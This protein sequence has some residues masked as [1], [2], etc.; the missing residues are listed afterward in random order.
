MPNEVDIGSNIA[1]P[2]EATGSQ[3]EIQSAEQ[4]EMSDLFNE[5][6]AS[7]AK[8][9]TMARIFQ[10]VYGDDVAPEEV[11]AFSLV[12][13]SELHRLARELQLEPGQTIV[14]LACGGGGP[15]LWVAREIQANLVGIDISSV[16]IAQAARRAVEFGLNHR[17]SFKVADFAA[18]GLPD[19]AFAGAISIDALWLAL[20]KLEALREVA[21]I[22]RPGA[23]FVFTT[24][25]ATIP[26]P[27]LPPQIDDHRPLLRQAGFEI[28][29]YEEAH[30]SERRQRGIYAGILASKE[31]LIQER[32]EQ[33]AGFM[34]QEAEQATGLLDGIDYIAH[35]RR[36]F[37]VVR[38][39]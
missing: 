1:S 36:I 32:G 20:D 39:M 21:R 15:G 7:S 3:P 14:D 25:D 29:R 12:S 23:R 37:V 11:S 8:S 38:R 18:T 13:L 16:A 6:Y 10:Q 33:A 24:W 17:A 9:P 27:G 35:A 30:D 22:L 31:A 34:I 4:P 2:D 28:E 19:A 26:I 5:A